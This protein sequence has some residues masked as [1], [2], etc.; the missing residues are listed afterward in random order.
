[1]EGHVCERRCRIV[2]VNASPAKDLVQLRLSLFGNKNLN[3]D[4]AKQSEMVTL[5]MIKLLFR[6]KTPPPSPDVLRVLKIK[7]GG[8]ISFMKPE[9]IEL[10]VR[11]TLFK[12]IVAEKI[13][14]EPPPLAAMFCFDLEVLA[15]VSRNY[16]GSTYMH[17]NSVNCKCG[18]IA[19]YCSSCETMSKEGSF[20]NANRNVDY[21]KLQSRNCR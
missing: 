9:A 4:G 5:F 17:F 1:M 15:E 19:C 10:C 6:L 8:S 12:T 13:Q 20:K 18:T 16:Y 3:V 7:S 2:H 21:H 14:S 11:D